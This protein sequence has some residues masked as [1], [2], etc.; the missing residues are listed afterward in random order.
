MHTLT[1]PLGAVF[2]WTY[3]GRPEMIGSIGSRQF[4]P[5]MS[6]VFHEFHSLTLQPL[7]HRYCIQ[8]R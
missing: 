5:G 4:R 1:L 6:R 3:Q 7:Q 8:A 2:I